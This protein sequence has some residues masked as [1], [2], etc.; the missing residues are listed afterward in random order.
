M[1][2]VETP[3]IG[4]RERKKARTRVAIQHAALALFRRNGY[5]ATTVEQIA[6]AADISPST[7]FRYFPTKEELV[8][9]D[10]YDPFTIAELRKQPAEVGHAEALRR[11]MRATFD[12]LTPDQLA[13]FE[14][15]I[16]LIYTVPELRSA[17][18]DQLFMRSFDE[19]VALLAE[20]EGS[21]VD[22]PEV[23]T[24][25]GAILGVCLS[26]VYRWSLEPHRDLLDDFDEALRLLD[27][28]FGR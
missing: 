20:R 7:F 25:T 1:S 19:V 18:S 15:R 21:T 24:L 11:A 8:L 6:A 22:D 23:R 17:A 13:D 14:Q 5:E 26:I 28:G 27:R 3:A 9:S 2:T 10:E 4:L 12:A 16:R